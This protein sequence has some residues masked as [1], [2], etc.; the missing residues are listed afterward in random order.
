MQDTRTMSH[1]WTPAV[2]GGVELRRDLFE[3]FLGAPYQ[4]PSKVVGRESV[5]LSST[6]KLGQK[7]FV[8]K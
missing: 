6:P 5:G 2:R 4:N 1:D 3:S 8:Q 7:R